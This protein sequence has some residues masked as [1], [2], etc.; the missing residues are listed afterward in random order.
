MPTRARSHVLETL[1]REAF[2]CLLTGP[3]GW[4]I[5]D[6][7]L[8][9]GIDLEVEIFD[10]DGAAT[11]LT[12]KAQL[13]GMEHPDHIGPFRDVNVDH[14]RYWSRLDVPVLL[15]AYDDSSATVF[16]RWIHALDLDLT[17]GQQ[18]VRIRFSEV[19]QIRAGDPRLRTTVETVRRLKSGAFGRPYP[20]QIADPPDHSMTHDYFTLV[21]TLGLDGYMR[22]D[23]SDFAF[24]VSIG[25][26]STRVSLPAE[27]GSLTLTYE[28][29][30]TTDD[31]HCDSMVMLASLLARMNRFGEAI[32]IA[33]GLIGR[34]RA[35][36][37]PRVAIELATAAYEIG[38]H[39]TLTKLAIE[40]LDHHAFPATQIYLLVLRQVPGADWLEACREDLEPVMGDFISAAKT[41]GQPS[42]AAFWAYNFAQFLYDKKARSDARVWIELALEL[43]PTG[44]GSRPEPQRLL[45]GVAWFEGTMDESVEAYSAAV[46]MG[47]LEAAGSQ[48]ADSLMHAGR[49][50]EA[51][52][53]ITQVLNAEPTNWRDYFVDAIVE[54]LVEHLHLEHQERRE[55]P[56]VGTVIS[57]RPLAELE[58]FLV[59]GDAL[60]P[61][62]WL[63]RCLEHPIE[64]LTTLMAGGFLSGN[65]LVMT[66]AVHGMLHEID[67]LAS[68]DNVLEL[69]A[70]LLRDKPEVKELLLS[71]DAPRCD[72]VER[73]RI[74]ELSL[75]SL[76]IVPSPPGVQFV[77]ENNTVLDVDA[78]TDSSS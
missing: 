36:D 42:L 22:L 9:Y 65:S 8:D 72:D 33:R 17:P 25:S 20:V 48:L 78:T 10:G 49:Y 77:D 23:R 59:D 45:G 6:V 60:N 66:M 70:W 58:T 27:V 71:E 50:N 16:G 41:N 39:S 35:F 63:A 55:Y 68:T 64:R 29:P 38:D 34:S 31:Q 18:T 4:V 75:R 46:A 7:A 21:D 56:P 5:R 51:R 3:L 28:H 44:Y 43:D 73:E 15:V 62:V 14:L 69:L 11:G 26:D 32:Q 54:E 74:N 53:V 13:K 57:G 76:E 61:S 67:G 40:S 47:G 1:S 2:S 37:S 52:E 30:V 24:G 12:F 19:D